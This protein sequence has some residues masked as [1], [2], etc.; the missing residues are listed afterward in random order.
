MKTLLLKQILP[1]LASVIVFFGSWSLFAGHLHENEKERMLGETLQN[2]GAEQ[3]AIQKKGI[4]DG[5]GEQ[6]NTLPSPSDVWSSAII[7]W[8]DHLE[9]SGKKDDFIAKTAEVNKKLKAQG[10]AEITYTGR[11][12]F[13]DQIITSLVTVFSGFLLAAFIAIP[14]GIITGLSP[15]LK[16][17][18][19]WIIQ[20]LR[21]VS[22]VVWFLLVYMIVIPILKD[23]EA[24][25]AYIVSFIAVGLCAMWA[26]LV[27]TAMGVASVSPDYVNVSKVLK[28]ST[29]KN[30][31][32]IIIPS[33]IP[34]I[35]TGLRITLSVSWMVLIAIELLAQNP[36]LG[37]F[38]WEEFQNGSSV[39]N[40]KII[41]A[42]FIIGII[43]F[44]LDQIM[45][46]VQKLASFNAPRVAVGEL[47]IIG[48]L[49]L[50]T[51]IMTFFKIGW[52]YPFVV[53][54]GIFGAGIYNY[55]TKS[56]TSA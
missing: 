28:L 26:T 47:F 3:A 15:T 38:V 52:I 41:V 33:S 54:A 6:P 17:S 1:I 36:G 9:I 4:E 18:I 44:I 39:S 21:P 22:P 24:D 30:V 14:L 25:K 51:L 5:T 50:F 16:T 55:K 29:F 48:G 35:F 13:V 7:L 11:P 19:S 8:E 46:T 31:F 42:M 43:G 40:A 10:K 45:A 12:S 23:S 56:V 27:N 53:L 49:V 34:L 37:S 20:I 32:K 2:Q